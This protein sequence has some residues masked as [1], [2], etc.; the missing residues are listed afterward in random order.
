[1]NELVGGMKNALERGANLDRIKQT[2]L[3]AGYKQEQIEEA[4]KEVSQFSELISQNFQQ[5]Q[6]QD[7]SQV[8]P[9]T[10]NSAQLQQPKKTSQFQPLPQ[11]Q[12]DTIIKKQANPIMVI[13]LI[14]AGIFTAIV[15]IFALFGKQ[16]LNMLL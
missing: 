13:L 15:V 16:I 2:F 14:L 4:A 7:S 3:N 9:P 5:Y 11:T 12:K 8:Q 1:M 6:Q 10:Q